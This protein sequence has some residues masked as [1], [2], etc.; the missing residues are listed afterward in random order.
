[1]AEVLAM[2]DGD[3]TL[4][5][6][7][8]SDMMS[9]MRTMR[10]VLGTELSAVPTAPH[11]L[12]KHLEEACPAR[13][14]VTA[15]RWCSVRS[16]VLG[17]LIRAGVPA[18][19]GRS[20]ESLS[21]EW[22]RLSGLLPDA[23]MRFRLSRFM[24][25]CSTRQVEPGDVAPATF[26][27]FHEA[28]QSMSL[29][30]KP[31]EI[32][33]TA[34]VVWN[35]AVD[36]VPGWPRTVVPVPSFSRRY[37]LGWEGFP[38]AFG[39][40]CKRFLNQ[41]VNQDVFADD[42]TPAI[43]PSTIDM[44]RKQIL[45][46]G[47]ALVLSGVPASAISSLA[48]LVTPEHARRA[49]GFF[50]QRPG[51][52]DS[53]YLYQHAVLLKTIARHWVKAPAKE[54]DT[55]RGY[56]S[57][58]A[59]RQTGMVE[60]NRAKLRQFDN[61][62]NVLTLLRLPRQVFEELESKDTGLRSDALRA[63][64][65]LAVRL[66]V[67][68]PMRVSNL[69]GLQFGRHILTTT[70][71]HGSV[72]HLRV[73]K[74]ETKT[75]EPFEALLRADTMALM[76]RFTERYRNRLS[77]RPSSTLFASQ[78]GDVRAST[79]FSTDFEAFVRQETGLLMNPHLFRHFAVRLVLDENSGDIETARLILGHRSAATTEGA[80]ADRTTAAAFL[81]LEAVIDRRLA[82]TLPSQKPSKLDFGHFWS[83]VDPEV[84]F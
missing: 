81:R 6:Q 21:P 54:V 20:N 10:R 32:Y 58:V 68:A 76:T 79:R 60:K 15:A 18:L 2:I 66:L 9:A 42:Y 48:C 67:V 65:A 45:Q 40:D 25:F 61:P 43:R 8:R 63:M 84:R 34:C 36:I 46:L 30:G 82:G 77:T 53:K 70:G 80:Y 75:S 72:T 19:P 73:P 59:V 56:A 22:A 26:E 24:R 52:Q 27:S 51:G 47:T 29:A 41:S 11:L 7:C 39:E 37:A 3:T 35:K 49:L 23:Q 71:L 31:K 16:L 69:V 5:P 14:G 57:R 62:E 13:F 55:L 78:R 1:M 17:A 33:R 50:R 74:T 28:V 4:R 44:R 64:F 12:R 38:T 83:C